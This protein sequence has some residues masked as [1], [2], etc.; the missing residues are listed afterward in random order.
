MIVIWE[1]FFFFLT[2]SANV[3][4]IEKHSHP[5][6]RE[7]YS[8]GPY[9]QSR[10]LQEFI[11]SITKHKDKL[12]KTDIQSNKVQKKINLRSGIVLCVLETPIVPLPP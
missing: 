9:N 11:K 2:S 10:N 1:F 8:W 6:I 4:N 7:V 3:I 5:S 12:R